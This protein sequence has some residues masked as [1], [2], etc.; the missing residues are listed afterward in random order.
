MGTKRFANHSLGHPAALKQDHETLWLIDL[1][2]RDGE[3][4]H[5]IQVNLVARLIA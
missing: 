2:R 4:L 3:P 5:L 1:L